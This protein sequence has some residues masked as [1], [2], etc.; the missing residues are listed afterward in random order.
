[1]KT[2]GTEP[3]DDLLRT[4][5]STGGLAVPAGQIGRGWQALRGVT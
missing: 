1:M 5:R 4:E 3:P 2:S